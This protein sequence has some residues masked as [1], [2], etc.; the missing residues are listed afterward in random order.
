M[1]DPSRSSPGRKTPGSQPE[2]LS[3]HAAYYSEPV[4]TP[5]GSRI[6]YLTG[7]RADQLYA[8]LRYIESGADTDVLPEETQPGEIAGISPDSQMDLRWIPAAGGDSTLVASSQGG[9]SPHFA[10]D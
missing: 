1:D 6:V 10:N 9:E 4:Y 8:D 2:Q 7:T 3:R 5:D